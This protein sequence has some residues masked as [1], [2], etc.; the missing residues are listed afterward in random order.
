MKTKSEIQRVSLEQLC[1]HIK[2][3][4]HFE[5][6]DEFYAKTI[7]P[8]SVESVRAAVQNLCQFG[9]LLPTGVCES[10]ILFVI[11]YSRN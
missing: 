1:L 10:N 3:F 2:L 8:P 6:L 11:Y 7:E 5:S 4:D 9:A